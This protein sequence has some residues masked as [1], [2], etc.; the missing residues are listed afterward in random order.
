MNKESNFSLEYKLDVVLPDLYEPSTADWEKPIRIFGSGTSVT[1][2][3]G[4]CII[5]IDTAMAGFYPYEFSSTE[6]TRMSLK[7]GVLIPNSNKEL[8]DLNL[9]GWLFILRTAGMEVEVASN[10]G[11]I[12][13]S[14]QSFS[15]LLSL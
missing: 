5:K 4:I 15:Y 8:G 2:E 14:A 10:D 3:F 1:E 6:D 12:R 13:E 11:R 9:L 7:Q